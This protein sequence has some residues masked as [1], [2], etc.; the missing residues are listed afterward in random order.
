VGIVIFKYE[1]GHNTPI[2]TLDGTRAADGLKGFLIVR[3]ADDR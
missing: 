3:L 1:V 2:L